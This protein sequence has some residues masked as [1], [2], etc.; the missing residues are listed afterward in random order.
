MGPQVAVPGIT[1]ELTGLD[2]KTGKTTGKLT[3]PVQ[4]AIGPVV[5]RAGRAGRRPR[6]WCRSPAG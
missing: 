2:V 4:L 3:F 6:R 5:R 1:S